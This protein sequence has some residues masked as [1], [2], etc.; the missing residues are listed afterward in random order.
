MKDGNKMTF[1]TLF[2]T[3]YLGSNADASVLWWGERRTPRRVNS[4][5]EAIP[6]L[7]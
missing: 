6:E 7:L 5:E 1:S 3:S 4:F 2:N